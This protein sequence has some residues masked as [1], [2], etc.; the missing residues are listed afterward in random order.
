[1][2]TINIS[3]KGSMLQSSILNDELNKNTQQKFYNPLASY[4][5]FLSN[6]VQYL[7]LVL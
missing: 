1:M 2:M 7:A 5:P 4:L 3:I 6:K